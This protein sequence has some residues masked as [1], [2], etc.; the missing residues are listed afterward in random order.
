M[1]L[2]QFVYVLLLL[3][4]L[5]F[6]VK[7]IINKLP[8][9]L[10]GLM[11]SFRHRSYSSNSYDENQYF[12]NIT[13]EMINELIDELKN[14][15]PKKPTLNNIQ[16]HPNKVIN[17]IPKDKF[18]NEEQKLQFISDQLC[19][20]LQIKK[21]ITVIV[22]KL[23]SGAGKFE[24]IDNMV[25]IY[26]N[27][28]DKYNIYQKLSILAHEMT[29]YYLMHVHKIVKKSNNE[30]EL[31]TEI[32]ACYLGFGFILYE[33]YRTTKIYNIDN[34][35]EYVK[36]GYVVHQLIFDIF[37]KVAYIRKQNPIYIYEYLKKN[38]SSQ[39]ILARIKLNKL[40]KEYK[41]FKTS[42]TVN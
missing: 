21:K 27:E 25:C 30:N 28:S 7:Q 22:M 36:V 41:T 12:N 34:N 10:S 37:I 18:W 32:A 9:L 26:I 40:I 15:L 19:T 38:Y 1:N 29:H 23:N 14:I 13:G 35:E 42:K 24:I 8:N 20:H 6:V 17:S 39:K 2:V 31:L 16:L 4:I 3:T 33:G 11:N 5:F